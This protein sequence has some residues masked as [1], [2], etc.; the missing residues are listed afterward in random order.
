VQQSFVDTGRDAGS[1]DERRYG[2]RQRRRV[3]T[4]TRGHLD[5]D[6]VRSDITEGRP[7]TPLALAI[8]VVD[9]RSCRAI[10]GAAVDVWHTDANGTYSGVEG[11]SGTFMRGTQVTGD[12]GRAKFT[13]VYPGW[14]HGRAVHVHIKVHAGGEVV[15]TGQ[16]Y[17]PDDLTDAV[18]ERS[19]YS[20]RGTRDTRNDADQIFTGSGGASTTL[21]PAPSAD[22]YR[23]Q[24]TLGVRT[25]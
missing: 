1:P 14:Y 16:L 5:V 3:C 21:A 13:T 6:K 15:H 20:A 17:F 24:V 25:A 9:T 10:A 12:D 7:G 11:D 18:Y 4:R 19:P 22:G 2:L 8:D 23:A